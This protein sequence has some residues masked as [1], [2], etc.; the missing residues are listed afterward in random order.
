M[1]FPAKS[2]KGWLNW[3]VLLRNVTLAFYKLGNSCTNVKENDS[4]IYNLS[5]NP[6]K[7]F[8]DVNSCYPTIQS[9]LVWDN[10]NYKFFCYTV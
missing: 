8:I 9:T 6:L 1:V 4:Y 2:C 7:C 10:N 3:S 5:T